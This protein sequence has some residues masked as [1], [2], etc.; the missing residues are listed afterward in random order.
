MLKAA[1]ALHEAGYQVRVVHAEFTDWA[2]QA[3]AAIVSTRKWRADLVRWKRPVMPFRFWYT[4]LRHKAFSIAAR[5]SFKVLGMRGLARAA[6]RAAPELVKAACCEPADLI[7]AGTTGGLAV[8]ACAAHR[9]GIPYAL[10]L[11]DFHSEEQAGNPIANRIM[12]AIENRVLPGA[13]FLTAGSLPI[14]DAYKQKY[15]VRPIPV[16]NT[17]PL[18]AAT[19]ALEGAAGGAFRLFWFSQTIGDDRGL[20]DVV[21]AVE[22]LARPVR[23]GL[24]GRATEFVEVLTRMANKIANLELEIQKPC[25]P[26]EIVERCR[27]WDVGLA[28]ENRTPLN[29]DLCLTNKI[30][31]YPLAGM[32]IAA[33][34][35]T[36]QRQLVPEF[37]EGAF[38][39][40]P[41]DSVA[42]A[43]GLNRWASE[44][45]ALARAKKASWEAAQRRWHWEHPLER[46][47]LL[48]AVERAI[49]KP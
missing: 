40:P 24:L 9:L 37:G 43:A 33:T 4:R 22:Q 6:T 3:A 8:G 36:A 11:E 26:D 21:R 18:P 47:A 28:M 46:G 2:D 29:R 19:P 49:G 42:L 48:D 44:P 25:F 14:A 13:A 30:F 32:A 10:D 39:Y 23:L 41:G 17:F 16:N 35:T 1:D 12:E 5:V 15:G 34:D 45:T 31:T 27:G 20:Q 38:L 7:Y